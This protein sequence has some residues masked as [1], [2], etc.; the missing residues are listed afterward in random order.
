MEGIDFKNLVVR[1]LIMLLAGSFIL[2]WG[3]EIIE[4]TNKLRLNLKIITMFSVILL[5]LI[6]INSIYLNQN[7]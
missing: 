3:F 1:L 6:E 2:L 5:S 7:K 4:E